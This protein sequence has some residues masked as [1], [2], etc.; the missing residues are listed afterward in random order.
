L[1]IAELNVYADLP[2]DFAHLS[3]VAISERLD[4][5]AIAYCALCL[6]AT[7]DVIEAS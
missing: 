2:K 6:I 4:N 5:A 3:L 7:L 1:H